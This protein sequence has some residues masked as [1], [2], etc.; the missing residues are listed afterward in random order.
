MDAGGVFDAGTHHVRPDDQHS[1]SKSGT[2]ANS[3]TYSNANYLHGA[4]AAADNTP[5]AI[6]AWRGGV[7]E[8][9]GRNKFVQPFTFNSTVAGS[10]PPVINN[11]N[12]TPNT[13]SP[14]QTVPTQITTSTSPNTVNPQRQNLNQQEAGIPPL[15][16]LSPSTGVTPADAAAAC[17]ATVYTMIARWAGDPA[18]TINSD[19]P[20]PY[21]V[22]FTKTSNGY[23]VTTSAPIKQTS[24]QNGQESLLGPINSGALVI[25]NGSIPGVSGE[26]PHSM[27]ATGLYGNS[28]NEIVANDPLTGQRVILS[29]NPSTNTVVAV[30]AILA[31]GSNTPIPLKINGVLNPAAEKIVADGL[32]GNDVLISKSDPN[33]Q[34]DINNKADSYVYALAKFQPGSLTIIAK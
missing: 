26:E 1:N 18:A 34:T 7:S 6:A 20:T 27:L 17:V 3:N 16:Q 28:K 9:A 33:Y 2:H 5:T 31:P 32:I 11:L 23:S 29:Y 24:L 19:K 13:T 12:T 25:I 14:T 15:G 30:I 22:T 10:T 8:L 4:I 21:G